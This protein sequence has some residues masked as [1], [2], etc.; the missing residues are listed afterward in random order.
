[1]PQVVHVLENPT[2]TPLCNQ[3]GSQG[4]PI[5]Q[6]GSLRQGSIW[7]KCLEGEV[8][9]GPQVCLTTSKHHSNGTGWASKIEMGTDH[10]HTLLARSK[11]VPRDHASGNR[12][13]KKLQTIRVALM[14]CHNTGG[15]SK[16]HEKHLFDCLEAH[17][18]ICAQNIIKEEIAR[19][20]TDKR[21][22]AELP[23]DV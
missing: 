2:G 19:K 10:E 15:N 23:E 12:A 8:A 3:L 20:V 11:L 16:C 22:Q 14:E 13:A 17:I 6:S 21:Y 1:M 4:T 18:T 7:G 9:R 5:F